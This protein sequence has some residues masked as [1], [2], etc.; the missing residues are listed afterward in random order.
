MVQA[1]DCWEGQ[2][3]TKQVLLIILNNNGSF[4]LLNTTEVY[5]AL[6]LNTDSALVDLLSVRFYNISIKYL[7]HPQVTKPEWQTLNNY[8]QVKIANR[9]AINTRKDLIIF[10]EDAEE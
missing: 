10:V 6:Y 4:T 3:Y 8:Y 9:S 5:L 1:Q 2:F 7:N